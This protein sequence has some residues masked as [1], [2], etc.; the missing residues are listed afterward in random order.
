[1]EEA[2]AVVVVGRRIGDSLVAMVGRWG[3]VLYSS[4]VVAVEG[5]CGQAVE[6]RV[7][8]HAAARR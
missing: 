1:M 4:K 3:F 5:L 8:G 7:V 6:R 2:A